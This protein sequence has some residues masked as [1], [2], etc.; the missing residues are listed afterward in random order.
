ERFVGMFL[1]AVEAGV[2]RRPVRIS[3]TEVSIG[4][5]VGVRIRHLGLRDVVGRAVSGCER[6]AASDASSD[7]RAES[8]QAPS[9]E[10]TW[11][12]HRRWTRYKGLRAGRATERAAR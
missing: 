9:T 10:P 7:H 6:C 5:R 2:R 11:R 1:W 12:T 4:G 3:A 8:Q